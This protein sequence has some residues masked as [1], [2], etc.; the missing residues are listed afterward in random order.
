[1]PVG[2]VDRICTDLRN[3]YEAKDRDAFEGHLRRLREMF[4]YTG[5]TGAPAARAA[6]VFAAPSAA[7]GLTAADTL[8]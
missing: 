2:P 7:E 1:M 5:P 6:A 8:G 4:A 3:A